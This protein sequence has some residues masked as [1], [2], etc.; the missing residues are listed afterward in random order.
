MAVWRYLIANS[1]ESRL[2]ENFS[3]MSRKIAR[4]AAETLT[5]GK[6][7]ICLDVFAEQGLIE[8]RA[9]GRCYQIRITTDGQKVDL[10]ASPIVM[11][12]RAARS[13]VC[14]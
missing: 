1:Q 6:T 9:C 5:L 11:R 8:L 10:D 13:G 14:P 2:Q 7:R 4:T 3:C 12:L